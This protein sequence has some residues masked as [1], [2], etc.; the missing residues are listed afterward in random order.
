MSCPD[1]KT[2][3]IKPTPP[4]NSFGFRHPRLAGSRDC[5]PCVMAIDWTRA[6]LVRVPKKAASNGSEN[7]VF[8]RPPPEADESHREVSAARRSSPWYPSTT[9]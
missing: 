4:R 5:S 6:D 7:E 8:R 1:S 2:L 9:D 3:E